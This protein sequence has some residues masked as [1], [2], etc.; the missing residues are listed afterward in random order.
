MKSEYFPYKILCDVL[1]IAAHGRGDGISSTHP[2]PFNDRPKEKKPT[3]TPK[4]SERGQV[5]LY[6]AIRMRRQIWGET[7]LQQVRT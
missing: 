2:H 6:P 3:P 5:P 1:P 4:T 7:F